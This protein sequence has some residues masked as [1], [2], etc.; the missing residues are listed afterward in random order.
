MLCI[1]CSQERPPS[2]EHVFPLAI[3]GTVTTD[4][5]CAVCNSTLGTRVDA[6]LSDFLPIRTRRAQLGLADTTSAAS[7]SDLALFIATVPVAA[8][9]GVIPFLISVVTSP[10]WLARGEH[11]QRRTGAAS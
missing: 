11:R 2:L 10:V 3:G 5:V 6:A 1:F 4:R 9:V 7:V 8:I